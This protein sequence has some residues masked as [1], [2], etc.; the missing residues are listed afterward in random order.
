MAYKSNTIKRTCCY[1]TRKRSCEHVKY[2]GNLLHSTAQLPS[3]QVMLSGPAAEA[4]TAPIVHRFAGNQKDFFRNF[5]ASMVK[6]GNISPLTGTDGDT[7][8]LPKD[9]QQTL[10]KTSFQFD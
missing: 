4:T 3:D 8:N 2:Y 7:K 5:A 9:Q 1:K 6:M 10:L